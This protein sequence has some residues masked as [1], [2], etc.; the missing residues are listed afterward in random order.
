MVQPDEYD[1]SVGSLRFIDEPPP[2]LS[3]EHLGTIRRGPVAGVRGNG[4]EENERK[5]VFF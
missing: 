1:I 4:K 5:R 2:S 3:S